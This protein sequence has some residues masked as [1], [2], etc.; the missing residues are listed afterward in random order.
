MRIIALRGS[1]DCGKSTTL[2][3]VYQELISNTSYCI[4]EGIREVLGNPTMND[5]ECVVRLV[6][7]RNIAFYTMGDYMRD[8]PYAIE[9]Y[10]KM[11]VDILILASNTN[12]Y[13]H[14]TAITRYPFTIVNKLIAFPQNEE[15]NNVCNF[16]DC[17]T[18][19]SLI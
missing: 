12:Y 4:D 8:I 1:R 14:L 19:L 13:N 18:I 11:K 5:F 9:R 10:A 6:D 2:N 16:Q 3:L 17:G 7:N 15:N